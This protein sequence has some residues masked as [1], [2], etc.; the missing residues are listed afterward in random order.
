MRQSETWLIRLGPPSSGDCIH[1]NTCPVLK[2][3]K[4]TPLRWRWAD[5]HPD[6]WAYVPWMRYCGV[7]DPVR[8]LPP[9]WGQS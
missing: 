6:D 7:C 8:N 4:G 5:E 2:R 1:L 9:L 3:A